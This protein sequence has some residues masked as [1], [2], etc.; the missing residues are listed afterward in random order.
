[1][2]VKKISV[3][4]AIAA[5]PVMA[6]GLI[7]HCLGTPDPTAAQPDI[8]ASLVRMLITSLAMLMPLASVIVTQLIYKEPVFKGMDISFKINRWWFAGW[9]LMP[10]VALGILG[11]SLLMPGAYWNG[12][13]ETIKMALQQMPEGIGLGGF[14]GMTILSGLMA[15][16]TINALF[17]FGEEIGWRGF[18]IKEMKGVKFMKASMITGAIWGLWHFPIILN[19]HNYPQHPVIGV[20]MMILM[21]MTLTPILNYFRLKS[22]S[23]IVPAIMHGTIN[24]VV[25]LSNMLVAPQNDLLIGGPGLAG[26]IVFILT[27]V[28]LFYYDR[29]I[30]KENLFT[31]EL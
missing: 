24:A 23:V 13:S 20:F 17:A 1:M 7:L 8:T 16:A 31:S 19:G 26:I 3:F 10:V 18:L 9:L 11:M 15:G 14:I 12:D 5:L 28:A 22:G 2:N 27:D 29:H 4:T 30:S 21:C 25:G 6:I